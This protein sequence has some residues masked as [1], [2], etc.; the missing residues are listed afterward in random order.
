[1]ITGAA[2]ADF[3]EGMALWRLNAQGAGWAA[4]IEV[5][6]S[7]I[8]GDHVYLVGGG[9]FVPP[10]MFVQEAGQVLGD[11]VFLTREEAL[12]YPAL[13]AAWKQLE[14]ETVGTFGLAEA[15]RLRSLDVR[16]AVGSLHRPIGD[17]WRG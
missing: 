13:L 9:K 6:V 3:S 5:A 2:L 10:Q 17:R 11:R 15:P 7:E 16:E 12:D 14:I 4:P 1:M 8:R